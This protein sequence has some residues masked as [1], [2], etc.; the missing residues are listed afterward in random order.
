MDGYGYASPVVRS[1]DEPWVGEPW[2]TAAVAEPAVSTPA[3]PVGES[4]TVG[5]AGEP[6]PAPWV[7]PVPAPWVGEPAV[8]STAAQATAQ[9]GSQWATPPV[10]T[11]SIRPPVAA[12]AR[13][14]AGGRTFITV[15]FW[16][17]L[18]ASLEVWWLDTP[19]HSLNTL[20]D[21]L[22]AAGRITGLIGGFVLVVQVLL[23]SRVGWLERWIGAHDLLMWHRELG[24]F[25]F[26][27]VLAH[28]ALVIVGYADSER[29]S[30]ARETWTMLTT[31]EDMIS[32]FVATGILV[33]VAVTAVRAI[34]RLLPYEGWYYIHLSSYLVLLLG[35]GH[36]FA[37]G[38]E[39]FRPG[40]GRWYWTA[41]YLLVVACLVWGRV[42]APL[43]LNLRH[44][45]RVAEVVPEGN[46]MI[47]IYITGRR[48]D[49]LRVRAGQYFRWRFLTRGC[50]WQAHP[51]SLSAAPNGSWLRLTVKVV[52]DHT[53]DLR[54]LRPG[55]RVFAEG[56]SG[57]FTADRR[58]RNRTLLIAAGSGIAPI[59]ALLEEVPPGAV[60]I[61]RAASE[62]ELVFRAELDWLAYEKE[63]YVWYVLG[64]RDDPWPK[65]VFTPKGM[66]QLVPDVTRRDVYLCGPQGLIAASVK[67][68]RRLRVP[69]KQIH[70]DPFEF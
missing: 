65:H 70:L 41:L 51:F 34:R 26:L 28:V 36:Q 40:F 24:G 6:V 35:Y 10:A 29:V 45:L 59:R 9:P 17:A 18:A 44:L 64:S 43:A 27:A 47:S 22:T 33:A 31:Y 57:V 62:Q 7:E 46:D 12:G 25:L 15:F 55:V 3:P 16:F 49:G 53:D 67:T 61:Y 1:P 14:G 48:L 58:R 4:A 42:L 32:A 69:R 13:D 19:A 2:A 63:A 56:P 66:R 52:G 68:L 20:G 21:V 23:M 50:W 8:D 38:Q 60:V 39:L 30:I 5:W 54:R 37:T 11:S